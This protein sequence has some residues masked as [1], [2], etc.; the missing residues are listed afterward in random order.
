M[1]AIHDALRPYLLRQK[2][3]GFGYIENAAIIY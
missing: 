2:S 3:F 1:S